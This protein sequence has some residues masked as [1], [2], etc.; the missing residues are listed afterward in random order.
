M[1]GL[2][3]ATL[4]ADSIPTFTCVYIEKMIPKAEMAVRLR[5]DGQIQPPS[6]TAARP[7]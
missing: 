5:L 1:R 7:S 6:S 4:A 2:E 3:V